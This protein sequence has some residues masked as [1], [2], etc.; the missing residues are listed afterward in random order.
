MRR[1]VMDP[2]AFSAY[3]AGVLIVNLTLRLDLSQ[4]YMTGGH[5][6]CHLRATVYGGLRLV[7]SVPGCREIGRNARTRLAL[8]PVQY[9]QRAVSISK[10][11]T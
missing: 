3:K 7:R 11:V 8:L 9:R 6:G 4:S 10:I 5:R 1:R 2:N